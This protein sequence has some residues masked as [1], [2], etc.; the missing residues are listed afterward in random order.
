[1]EEV[2][3]MEFEEVEELTPSSRKGG[4]GSTNEI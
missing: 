2:I 4:F 3:D 1:L